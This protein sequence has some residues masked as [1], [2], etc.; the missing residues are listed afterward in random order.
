MTKG[1]SPREETGKEPPSPS[2]D[3]LPRVA[4]PK[5]GR[6]GQRLCPQAIW[7]TV[8]SPHLVLSAP[9]GASQPQPGLGAPGRVPVW[10][11]VQGGARNPKG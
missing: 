3:M 7:G 4:R 2:P 10:G 9:E 5:V 11:W 6:W 1:E 8:R